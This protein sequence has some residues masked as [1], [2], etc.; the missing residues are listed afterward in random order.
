MVPSCYGRARWRVIVIQLLILLGIFALYKVYIPYH[1]RELS[2]REAA[3]RDQEISGFFQDAVMEDSTLEISVPVDGA[4]VKRHP[5]KLRLT[6]SPQ[7]AESKLGVPSASTT[8]FDGGQH[9]TWLGHAHTLEASFNAGHL[10]C[11][12]LADRATGHGVLVYESPESWH[13]Y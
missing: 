10:Y 12:S 4:I 5:Q 1:E 7:E 8:D 11:L 6:F 13:P 9:L 2:R 3:A